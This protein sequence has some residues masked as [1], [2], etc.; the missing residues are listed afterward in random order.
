MKNFLVPIDFSEASHN[1]AKYAV[2]LGEVLKAKIIFLNVVP[3][4]LLIEDE[5]LQSRISEQEH[6]VESNKELILKE[7]KTLS[8]NHLVTIEGY[9]GEGFPSDMILQ[10][11]Q[12][13]HADL[14][15]M[16]MKGK[17]KST[18]IFGST[19]T[20]VIKKS[21]FSVLVI[22]EGASYQSI[23]TICLATDLNGSN[24]NEN[25]SILL[26]IGE[27]YKSS[28]QIL[29]VKKPESSLS[30]QE[31]LNKM[32]TH[33]AF[34]GMKYDFKVVED[35]NVIRGINK[36]LEKNPAEILTMIARKHTFLDRLFG[37]VHTKQMTYETK[38]PLL[39]LKDK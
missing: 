39:V 29:N 14:I 31:F 1:A 30:D 7:I 33:F 13:N 25:L 10:I 20:S 17:G 32:K 19:T 36:F 38:I 35:S 24:K 8:K 34:D 12:E 5:S 16:G 26:E 28:I 21:T 11:A 37:T 15:I 27:K 9:V 3:I 23:D 6:L 2:S 22:P 18:S 4:G